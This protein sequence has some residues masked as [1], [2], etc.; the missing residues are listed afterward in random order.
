[1]VLADGGAGWPPEGPYDRVIL[2]VGADDVSPAW[3]DQLVDGGRLVLPLGLAGSVQHCVAL[4]K[5]GRDL[6][7]AE[8]CACGFMPLRGDM[9]RALQ[10]DDEVVSGWLAEPGRP[11][12]YTVPAADLR[13]GFATW[14]L[15]TR[16]GCLLRRPGAGRAAGF[17]LRDE[18]GLAMID[19][20][21][22]DGHH[23]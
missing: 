4:V 7:S 9:A 8:L 23:P 11:T 19:G 5:R 13:A 20:E 17:G 1:V 12:G 22:V 2:T 18:E 15:L 16:S 21:A 3:V 14:L 6:E 10:P